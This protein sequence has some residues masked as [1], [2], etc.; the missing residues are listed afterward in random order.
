L[1]PGDAADHVYRQGNYYYR[2]VVWQLGAERYLAA[3][4]IFARID[5]NKKVPFTYKMDFHWMVL[6]LPF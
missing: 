3:K 5:S 1:H 4:V 2:W 6:F